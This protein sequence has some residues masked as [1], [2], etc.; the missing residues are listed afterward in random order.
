MVKDLISFDDIKILVTPEVSAKFSH[1]Y[2]V[3]NQKILLF[4]PKPVPGFGGN[5]L[6]SDSL[7]YASYEDLNEVENIDHENEDGPDLIC[8]LGGDGLL[9]YASNLFAGPCPP[10]LCISAGSLGFLTPFSRCEMVDAI[11]ISLGL[12]AKEEKSDNRE[13]E[14]AWLE[15]P[16]LKLPVQ[17]PDVQGRD[18]QNSLGKEGSTKV[19]FGANNLICLSMRMRLDCRVFNN[20]GVVRARF[21]VLNEVVIDRGSSPYL[22]ALECFC[23]DV[24]LTTVQADG[25]I[26]STPTGSTAYSMAAGG[27]E[28]LRVE[29]LLEIIIVLSNT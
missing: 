12:P 5:H 9:M 13:N 21:N 8:T 27:C 7:Q 25:V 18:E 14:K 11:R 19:K 1:Y 10:I 4:D 20:E 16:S 17:G 29:N 26:F 23:D 6:P 24:H 28:F 3:D 15:E 22:A 2:D